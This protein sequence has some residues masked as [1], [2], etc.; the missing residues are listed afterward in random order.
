M[1]RFFGPSSFK[2]TIREILYL[3]VNAYFGWEEAMR[4]PIYLRKNIIKTLQ[5]EQEGKKSAEYDPKLK[6]KDK[7]PNTGINGIKFK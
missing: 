7:I 6:K 2:N 1:H 5:A 3:K 4:L